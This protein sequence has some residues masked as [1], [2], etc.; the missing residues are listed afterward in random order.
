MLFYKIRR[1][2]KQNALQPSHHVPLHFH[3][4]LHYH[5]LRS[6]S[7]LSLLLC[8]YLQWLSRKHLNAFDHKH[9]LRGY[10][11]QLEGWHVKPKEDYWFF[12][13]YTPV[14]TKIIYISLV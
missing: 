3:H 8:G 7:T 13:S 10:L 1:V 4:I 6:P 12:N 14:L 2:E 9:H 5:E 11:A